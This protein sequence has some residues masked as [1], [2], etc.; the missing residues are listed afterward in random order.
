M[1][2]ILSFLYVIGLYGAFTAGTFRLRASSAQFSNRIP[3][4]TLLMTLAI[5]IP[6]TFQFFFPTL[7][8]LF[9]R[10][11]SR[12]AAGEWWRVVTALF[13][14]DGGIAGSLFNLVSLLLLG[15]VAEQRWGSRRWLFIFLVGG[16]LSQFIAFLWQPMGAGNSVANFSLAGSMAMSCLIS[17]P[18]PARI[19][20]VM[21]LAACSVLLALKDIHGAA[22]FIGCIIALVLI[23]QERNQPSKISN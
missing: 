23:W 7:L 12:I 20:S 16:I 17:A 19:A 15:S 18:R 21:S 11:L 9:E 1:N 2:P 22:A 10:D 8:H 3:R 13:V 6:S 5:A 14:Q 4:A